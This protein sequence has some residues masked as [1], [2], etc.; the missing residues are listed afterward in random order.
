LHAGSD[1][2]SQVQAQGLSIVAMRSI[3]ALK[4]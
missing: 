4:R 3:T 2:G 1:T